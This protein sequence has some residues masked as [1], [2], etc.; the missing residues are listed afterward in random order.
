MN[1]EKLED[2][3]ILNDFNS[4]LEEIGENL[5]TEEKFK[6]VDNL[7]KKEKKILRNRISAQISREKKKKEFEKLVQLNQSLIDENMMLKKR[8]RL[9]K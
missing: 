2:T 8:V 4:K 6:N 5:D 7:D 3:Q 9:Q 1:K